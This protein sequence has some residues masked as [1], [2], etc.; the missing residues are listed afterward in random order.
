MQEI[1]AAAAAAEAAAQKKG[2]RKISVSAAVLRFAC[3]LWSRN[4][5]SGA[6]AGCQYGSRITERFAIL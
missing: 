6:L 3:L 1:E 4:L 2:G 5:F